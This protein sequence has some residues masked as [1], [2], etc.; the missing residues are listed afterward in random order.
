MAMNDG[1]KVMGN[2]VHIWAVEPA[3]GKGVLKQ[4]G[5]EIIQLL[6]DPGA[7]P[8]TNL[9]VGERA[10]AWR[11]FGTTSSFSCAHLWPAAKKAFLVPRTSNWLLSAAHP[12]LEN[13]YTQKNCRSPRRAP[14][15]SRTL[16]RSCRAK[17]TK[18]A[19]LTRIWAV[20]AKLQRYVPSVNF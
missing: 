20:T 7:F 14:P 12:Q 18:I 6:V 13:E 1:R 4:D 2:G 11:N 19:L 8:H 3:R 15:M 17:M 10:A 5:A 16:C 9:R